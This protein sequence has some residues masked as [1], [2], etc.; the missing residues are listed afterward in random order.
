MKLEIKEDTARIENMFKGLKELSE[1]QVDVGLL[2]SAGGRLQ[3]ILGVQTHG[4][5]IMR[6]PPRPVV[7]PALA[8]ADTQKAIAAGFE[9][10]MEAAVGGDLAGVKAGLE[11]AGKSG[12][13]GIRAYIDSG[14]APAN[15]PVT[16]SG[17]WIYNRVA[18][19]GV[20]V[21]GKGSSKPLYRTGALYS[22]F[23]YE[24]K[25]RG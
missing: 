14:I 25:K 8:Q 22:A 12:A 11:E 16:V 19:K 10:A 3:F 7:E 23:S 20:L 6:I 5:P 18:K 1:Q 17:G 13:D 24:V 4:S 2:P 21:A 15:S 9:Q